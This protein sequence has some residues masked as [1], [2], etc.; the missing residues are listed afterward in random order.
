MQGSHH[1]AQKSITETL[2][3][4]SAAFSLPP[5]TFSSSNSGAGPLGLAAVL[6]EAA[7]GWRYGQPSNANAIASAMAVFFMADYYSV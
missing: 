4:R 5:A 6:S 2:P 3:F 1:V 7:P